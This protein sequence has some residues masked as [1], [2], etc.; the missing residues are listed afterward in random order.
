MVNPEPYS[1]DTARVPLNIGYVIK[2]SATLDTPTGRVS[3]R[4]LRATVSYDSRRTPYVTATVVAGWP[5]P[6]VLAAL[7]P[8]QYDLRLRV[9]AGYQRVTTGLTEVY[10]IASLRVQSVVRDYIT[11]EVT[12]TAA[13][14][15]AVVIAQSALT[16]RTFTGST[17]ITAGIQQLV[18]DALPGESPSWTIAEGLETR[19]FGASTTVRIGDDLWNVLTEWADVLRAK[20]WHDGAGK[21]RLFVPP[22]TPGAATDAVLAVGPQGSI[23][24]VTLTDDRADALTDLLAIYDYDDA[25]AKWYGYGYATTGETPR[26]VRVIRRNRKPLDPAGTAYNLMRRGVR[27]GHR[28]DIE[29][30]A[31]LWLRAYD[32]VSVRIPGGYSD[33]L[34]ADSVTFTLETGTMTVVGTAPVNN[35]A[36]R[37]TVTGIGAYYSP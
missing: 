17:S 9:N 14:T 8:V 33:R 19:T 1:P 6:G 15:E 32:T 20:L 27:R 16:E 2:Y 25:G 12:I 5:P 26:A 30:T 22:S 37:I 24:R 23:T 3:L 36:S 28:M 4:A 10:E 35:K 13:S 29:A 34:L 18:A 7:D 11:Q 21:W 31:H